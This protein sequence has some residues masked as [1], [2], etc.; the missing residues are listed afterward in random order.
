MKK[1]TI[2]RRKR[3]VPALQEHG[4]DQSSPQITHAT[5][6]PDASP[7]TNSEQLQDQ[8]TNSS[9][10]RYLN[11]G[12]RSREESSDHRYDPLPI[13]LTGFHLARRQTSVSPDI[14][15]QRNAGHLNT[16]NPPVTI[17]P[18]QT[19]SSY[20]SSPQDH[21]RKRSFSYVDGNMI[22][23]NTPDS[24]RSTRLGSISSIL[25]PTQNTS[26]NTEESPMDISYQKSTTL[27]SARI[28]SQPSVQAS[29]SLSVP[30]TRSR[31]LSHDDPGGS[32]ANIEKSTRKAQLKREA[33]AMRKMLRAK[34]QELQDLDG[35]G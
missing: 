6:S 18:I 19:T 14:Y 30:E 21:S 32:L 20:T 12:L 17:P 22:V 16:F 28:P 7:S 27:Q 33:E 2:K 23:E 29:G 10:E 8:P 13:D 34:E 3:V 9:S 15:Q 25:N 24:A 35:E 5:V 1:S 4:P 31:P 26:I 11:L